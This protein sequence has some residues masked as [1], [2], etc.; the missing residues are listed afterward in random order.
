M[1]TKIKLQLILISLIMICS[2]TFAEDSIDLALDKYHEKCGYKDVICM[3]YG[4]GGNKMETK[5]WQVNNWGDFRM[6]G[7]DQSRIRSSFRGQS[8]WQRC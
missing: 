2:S 4:E 1:N 5:Y 6:P 8:S 7:I 3:M